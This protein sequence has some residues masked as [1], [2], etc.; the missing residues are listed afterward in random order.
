MN[1][2]VFQG[3]KTRMTSFIQNPETNYGN[4]RNRP[5]WKILFSNITKTEVYPKEKELNESHPSVNQIAII[6]S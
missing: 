6:N 3:D 5:S 4:F 1:K 2:E